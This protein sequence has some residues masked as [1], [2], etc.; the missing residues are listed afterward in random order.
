MQCHI[1]AARVQYH[2][3]VTWTQW[4]MKFSQKIANS[5]SNNISKLNKPNHGV[6]W[7]KWLINS[8]V[9]HRATLIWICCLWFWCLLVMFLSNSL[10]IHIWSYI[11]EMLK[12]NQL[13]YKSHWVW[14]SIWWWMEGREH[15]YMITSKS[16][17]SHFVLPLDL[18]MFLVSQW[19]FLVLIC[20]LDV[21]KGTQ[22]L[23]QNWWGTYLNKLWLKHIPRMTSDQWGFLT[24]WIYILQKWLNLPCIVMEWI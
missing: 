18:L 16:L 13:L 21:T 10:Q 20:G 22:Q 24:R 19:L 6:K 5:N 15:V 8:M 23:K 2:V 9:W 11:A 3:N 1:K 17:P 7:L 12:Q 4:W 14:I